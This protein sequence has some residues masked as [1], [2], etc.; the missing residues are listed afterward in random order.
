MKSCRPAV[1]QLLGVVLAQR[2]AGRFVNFDSPVYQFY[3]PPVKVGMAGRR[4]LCYCF[5]SLWA[6]FLIIASYQTIDG[7]D[8]QRFTL[9]TSR[10]AACGWANRAGGLDG[11]RFDA[12]ARQRTDF[13]SNSADADVGD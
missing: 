1:R 4:R 3:E 8:G 12:V 13:D 2:F 6:L 10:V 7:N 9:Q 11:L 5:A